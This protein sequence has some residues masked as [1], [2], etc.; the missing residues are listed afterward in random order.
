MQFRKAFLTKWLL[1]GITLLMSAQAGGAQNVTL[2][3]TLGR[4]ATLIGPRYTIRQND[5]QTVGSN[6]FH[7]FGRFSLI[8]GEQA[9]FQSDSRIRNIFSRVTGGSPAMID[10]LISTQSTNV[11][12]YLINPSGI[13]FGANAE[14]DIGSATRGSFFAT[15]WD[16]LTWA[17]GNQFSATHPDR[18]PT[19]LTLVG[20]PSSFAA[21]RSPAAIK[22]SEPQLE[23]FRGQN[24]VLLGGDIQ[25]DGAIVTALG[26]RVEL[27]AAAE[28]GTARLDN[29][30]RLQVPA[31]LARADVA[32]LNGAIVGVTSQGGGEITIL[33]RNLDILGGNG[34][35]SGMVAGI[36]EFSGSVNARSG[37][38]TLDAT[39]DITLTDSVI[40]NGL[41]FGARGQSGDITMRGRSLTVGEGA[42][43]GAVT[44][45]RGNAGNIFLQVSDRV[46]LTGAN[47]SLLSNVAFGAVGQ[48]GK[49]SIQARSLH[50]INGG[51]L[52]ATTFGRGNAGNDRH[53]GE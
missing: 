18:S 32:L 15:T 11:N 22:L 2:D 51:A 46:T 23:V 1:S 43:I 3:G 34:F 6:L 37:D 8:E 16:G 25:L 31:G 53:S 5:G 17:N 21:L 28:A 7:S 4:A 14:L 19:L 10:G 26:G 42:S 33:A 20:D 39:G 29:R 48:G 9:T 35:K 40:A 30:L 41:R 13:L 47:T 52:T 44:Q 27:A 36:G 24:L 45:G 38:I 49:I 12:F 50:L